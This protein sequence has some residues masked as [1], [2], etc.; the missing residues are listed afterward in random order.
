MEEINI[1]LPRNENVGKRK[2]S[3]L[4]VDE[5]ETKEDEEV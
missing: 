3:M 2:L 5:K 1:F 4:V